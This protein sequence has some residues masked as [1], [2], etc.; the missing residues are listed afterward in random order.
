MALTLLDIWIGGDTMKHK[1]MLC[2]I[3]LVILSANLAVAKN[4]STLTRVVETPESSGMRRQHPLVSLDRLPYKNLVDASKWSR[5]TNG[6][7]LAATLR[8]KNA[9][10][11][12]EPDYCF[13]CD[14]LFSDKSDSEMAQVTLGMTGGAFGGCDWKCCFKTCMNSAM[15]GTGNL[16][17]VN[18]TAC[19]VT[20][21]AWPCAICAGCGVVG[22]AAIE[23][24]GLHCC[25]DPGCPAR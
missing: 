24:C 19:G 4:S 3:L 5:L 16:C 21:N 7:A 20:G 14:L 15:N 17:T 12:Q 9:H 11:V 25:V 2:S 18:C 1:L 8:K 13:D 6:R 23:F 22:F 10:A